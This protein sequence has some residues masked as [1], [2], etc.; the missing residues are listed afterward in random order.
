MNDDDDLI[1]R[2]RIAAHSVRAIAKALSISVAEVNRAIDRW[3][4][5]VVNPE[6]RKQ[7]FALELARLD[8][9]QLVFYERASRATFRLAPWSRS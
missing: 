8:E 4:E 1:V 2:Q 7:T 5:T 9:M 3:A 6:L